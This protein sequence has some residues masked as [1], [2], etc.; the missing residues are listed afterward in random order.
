MKASWWE[1]LRGK[2]GLVL[3]DGAMPSKSLIQFS[4]DGWGCVPSLL[5]DLRPNCGRGNENNGDLLKRSPACTA[6]LSAP[7]PVAGHHWP[8]PPLAT[9]PAHSWASLGQSL[10]GSLVLSPGSW[11]VQGFVIPSKSLSSQFC[12]SS[13]VSLWVLVRT[14][15]VWALGVCLVGM[16][17]DSKRNFAPPTVLLGLLLCPWT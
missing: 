9:T 16:G 7:N 2:L 5:F 1:R 10:M 8:M 11:C 15:F 4:V 13:G 14:G 6:T 12:L 3:M 17:F